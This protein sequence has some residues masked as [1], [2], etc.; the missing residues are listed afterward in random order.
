MFPP[1]DS[2]SHNNTYLERSPSIHS[3]GDLGRGGG[4]GYWV[5]GYHINT[6]NK[7]LNSR[8]P[9]VFWVNPWVGVRIGIHGDRLGYCAPPPTRFTAVGPVL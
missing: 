3:E 5:K 6:L 7:S 9:V 4:G 2:Y 1:K 8:I